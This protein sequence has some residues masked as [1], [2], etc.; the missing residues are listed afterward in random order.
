MHP[1][2]LDAV[3]VGAPDRYLG[4]RIVLVVRAEPGRPEPHDLADF[5]R[6]AGLAA[7]KIPDQVLVVNELPATGVG[8]NSRRDL[9]RLLADS[10]APSE[11]S[12]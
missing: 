12:R 3:A 4:E 8:K 6:S 10:L 11:E 2:V 7:Y 1:A 5:L 9:R